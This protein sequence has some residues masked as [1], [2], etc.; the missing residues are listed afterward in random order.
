[1]KNKIMFYKLNG[2]LYEVKELN[3]DNLESI[4]GMMTRCSLKNGDIK[5]GYADP[6]RTFEDSSFDNK[7]HDY[8]L[9]WTWDNLDEKNNMLMGPENVKYNQS[10]QKIMIKDIKQVKAILYSNDRWG[11]KLTNR[12]NIQK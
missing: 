11:G 1:M 9:L 2:E 12:F 3:T 5:E 6:F 7:V 10:I 4:N 8:I